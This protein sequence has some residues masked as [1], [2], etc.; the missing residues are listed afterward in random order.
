MKFS[1]K[2]IYASESQL[3]D[4]PLW[5]HTK[6]LMQTSTGYGS[7]LVTRN[8][9]KLDNRLYRIYCICYSNAGTCY[10]IKNKE[11]IIIA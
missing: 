11:K 8:K 3:I 1:D 2:R 9:I 10:I 7:K 6:N 4:S 5:Y